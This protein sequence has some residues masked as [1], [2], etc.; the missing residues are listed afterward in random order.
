MSRK[1]KISQNVINELR[2]VAFNT[3]RENTNNEALSILYDIIPDRISELNKIMENLSN[4]STE[5][6]SKKRKIENSENNMTEKSNDNDLNIMRKTAKDESKKF[7]FYL[8]ILRSWI[9]LNSPK[10]E[11]GNNFG[12]AI[13]QEILAKIDFLEDSASTFLVSEIKH[14]SEK[15]DFSKKINKHPNIL[16]YKQAKEEFIE[17]SDFTLKLYVKNLYDNYNILYDLISKNLEKIKEPKGIN[18]HH[19][20]L[21]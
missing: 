5:N 15:G 2:S 10:I 13:Q 16:E 11:D 12:V 20:L 21:T 14:L 8:N 18:H 4:G 9:T 19:S 3:Y 7:I 6:D 1:S 17:Y